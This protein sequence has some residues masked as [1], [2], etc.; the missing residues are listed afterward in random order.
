MKARIPLIISAVFFCALSADA[1]EKA[2]VIIK[3]NINGE[4][5]VIEKE[6]EGD[7]MQ[8]IEALLEAEGIDFDI[9]V[10]GQENRIIEIHIDKDEEAPGYQFRTFQGEH[11]SKAFLGVA[12]ADSDGEKGVRISHVTKGS[13]AESAGLKVGDLITEFGTESIADFNDLKEAVTKHEPGDVVKVKYVRDGK[14]MSAEATLGQTEHHPMRVFKGDRDFQ[15]EFEG[16]DQAEIEKQIMRF[17]DK[18]GNMEDQ[19]M[20]FRWY[21]EDGEHEDHIE[22]DGPGFSNQT[23]VIIMEKIS[24]EEASQVN[25]NANPKISTADNLVLDEMRFFPNPGD[26]RFQLSFEAASKGDLEVMIFDTQGKKVYY[27][28][29]ADF[30]GNYRNS[31]DISRRDAGNYFMQIIQNGKTYSRKLIKE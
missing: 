4:E 13:A 5:T 9:D 15:F 26:G 7:N 20:M 30:E 8:E 1:Q 6:V 23:V 25:A 10:N 31:I 17:H 21:D 28:M 3:K 29:L 22:F 27:E 16:E 12:P 2:K 14:K 11:E 19:E 24:P 18:Y